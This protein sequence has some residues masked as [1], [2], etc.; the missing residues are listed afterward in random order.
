MTPETLA[1]ARRQLQRFD[2]AAVRDGVSESP[3]VLRFQAMLALR[4]LA[5]EARR[6]RETTKVSR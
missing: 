1:A 3:A 2:A 5:L 6:R 4:V